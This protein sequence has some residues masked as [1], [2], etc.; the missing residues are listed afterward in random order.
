M[1][2]QQT[3]TPLPVD[4]DLAYQIHSIKRTVS[5]SRN[6]IFDTD[7][8]EKHHAD[9]FWAWALALAGA[10]TPSDT[11]MKQAAIVGRHTTPDLRRAVRRAS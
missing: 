9:A 8:N 10:M 1:L 6:L 7:R 2:S 4:R 3:N 11:G 5:A